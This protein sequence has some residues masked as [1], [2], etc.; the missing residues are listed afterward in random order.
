LR[1]RQRVEGRGLQGKE[2]KEGLSKTGCLESG[3][4]MIW[5]DYPNLILVA[6]RKTTVLSLRKKVY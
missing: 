1:I 4:G 2:G 3:F 6:G 5:Y